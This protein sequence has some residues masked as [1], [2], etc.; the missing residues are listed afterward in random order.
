MPI[1]TREGAGKCD[2]KLERLA[3][4]TERKALQRQRSP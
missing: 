4:P 1:L 3:D 2:N